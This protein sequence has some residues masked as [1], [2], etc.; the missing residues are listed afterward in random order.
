M[1]KRKTDCATIT[2]FPWSVLLSTTALDQSAGEKSLRY[3]E[4][5]IIVTN[6]FDHISQFK[7]VVIK[8]VISLGFVGSAGSTVPWSAVPQISLKTMQGN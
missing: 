1:G 7:V 3:H 6:Y 8:T 2:S 5:I 4:K